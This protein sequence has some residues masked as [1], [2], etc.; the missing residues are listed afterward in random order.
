[1]RMCACACGTPLV[2]D[3]ICLSRQMEPKTEKGASQVISD[4]CFRWS[5]QG[6]LLLDYRN[7]HMQGQFVV[8]C[9]TLGVREP[10]LKVFALF[11]R[12]HGSVTWCMRSEWCFLKSDFATSGRSAPSALPQGVCSSR[13]TTSSILRSTSLFLQHTSSLVLRCSISRTPGFWA[14]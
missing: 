11:E 3:A 6:C 1:M 13:R 14:S 5:Y 10:C 2:A 7:W 9:A 12:H 8:S 4:S